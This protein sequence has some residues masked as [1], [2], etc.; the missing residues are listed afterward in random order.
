MMMNS[1]GIIGYFHHDWEEHSMD[2]RAL[3]A[4]WLGLESDPLQR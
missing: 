1:D 2:L 4:H 3:A